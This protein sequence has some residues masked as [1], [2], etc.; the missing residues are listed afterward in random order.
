MSYQYDAP[1]AKTIRYDSLTALVDAARK[2][3][4]WNRA[5]WADDAWA[6][7]SFKQAEEYTA[8]GWA[9]GAREASDKVNRIADRLLQSQT[10]LAL[11]D[12][13]TFDVT[14]GVYDI[15]GYLSGEPECWIRKEP[16]IAKRGVSVCVNI[17]ASCGVAA[18]V[19]RRRGIAVAALVL[20]LQAKGYPVTVDVCQVLGMKNGQGTVATVFRVIDAATGSQLDL[21]RLVF[22]IAHPVIFRRVM[23]TITVPKDWDPS[24]VRSDSFPGEYDLKL[25]GVHLEQ[26]HRWMDGG[27]AWIV[28][29]FERQT[30]L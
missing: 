10:A 13:L 14:G 28:S 6:G 25:G 2:M 26:A 9:D 16:Q 8:R 15:G 22:A 27:E 19:M 21:D 1:I 24:G 11:S 29:E 5:D 30:S 18:D 17:T 20:A 12:D 4:Y 23:R 7:G 3:P